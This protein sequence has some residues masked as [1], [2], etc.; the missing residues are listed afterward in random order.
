[1]PS[2]TFCSHD[3]TTLDEDKIMKV[4]ALRH[5]LFSFSMVLKFWDIRLVPCAYIYTSASCIETA[6]G[7]QKSS[8]FLSSDAFY[9]YFP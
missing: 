8:R 4:C 7:E 5:F 2:G 3:V 6:L 1:M 9:F